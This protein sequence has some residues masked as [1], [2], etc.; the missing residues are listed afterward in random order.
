[1]D[2]EDDILPTRHKPDLPARAAM[3]LG[4]WAVA[5]KHGVV[6]TG[7]LLVL[8]LASYGAWDLLAMLLERS[9]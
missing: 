2:H 4:R 5:A 1:V 3:F 7:I 9:G 6:L 8:A